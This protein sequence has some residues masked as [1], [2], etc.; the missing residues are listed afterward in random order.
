MSQGAVSV[1]EE[2]QEKFRVQRLLVREFE[3]WRWSV[4][5]VQSTLGASILSLK[6]AAERFS[7]L[8][9]DE[10]AE[11]AAASTT[12]E[13]T[14]GAA[15][16]YDKINYLMLMMVDPHVHFHVLPRY[17]AA[18]AFGGREWTDA[19]WPALPVLAGKPEDEATLTAVVERLRSLLR[20][21]Q[22]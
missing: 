10:S 9:R 18:R 12:M 19:G 1:L 14:L 20:E 22:L 13:R 15:F 7:A 6:R 11:L 17:A 21:S 4:R 16:S 2:F 5:P 3:H 8:S